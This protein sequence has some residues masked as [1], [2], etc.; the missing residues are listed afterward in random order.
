MATVTT[1]G[2]TS[3]R[4]YRY[5]LF[6]PPPANSGKYAVPSRASEVLYWLEV[7]NW[8][9]PGNYGSLSGTVKV[10][11]TPQ[12]GAVVMLMYRPSRSIVRQRITDVN[13]AF[14]FPG[15]DKTAGAYACFALLPNYNAQAYDRLTPA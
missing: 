9:K 3:L 11:S 7:P 5:Q 10:G 2:I 14:S 12:P 15:L 6:T 13:G 1:A 4:T 8:P